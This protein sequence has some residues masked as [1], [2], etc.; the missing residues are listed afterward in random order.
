LPVTGLGV[1]A[2]KA[3]V[4]ADCSAG[5][6]ATQPVATGGGA[7]L[8]IGATVAAGLAAGAV[9]SLDG[10]LPGGLVPVP[11]LNENQLMFTKSA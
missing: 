11:T 4:L 5:S 10:T 3:A 8:G 1:L 9:V 2:K 7:V 6:T